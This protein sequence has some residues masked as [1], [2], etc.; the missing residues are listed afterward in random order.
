MCRAVLK[1]YRQIAWGAIFIW[2][3]IT[4]SGRATRLPVRVYSTADG[5]PSNQTNCV[6]RDSRGFLWF[7]TAEGLSRFDGYTFTN[8]GVD[9][10]LPD[11]AVTDFLETR[12]G[13]YWVATVR[14]L[15]RFDPK[16][17]PK[18][19]MFTVYRAEATAVAQEVNALLEDHQGA[20]WVG[21]NAGVFCLI[22]TG[23]QWVFRR[24][25]WGP[26]SHAPA[27]GF[28]EDR[29]G[30]LWTALYLGQ[31]A[32]LCRWSTAGKLDIFGNDFLRGNRILA[33][34]E[35]RQGRIWLG[36]YHGLALLADRPQADGP[37]I[38]H[39][40]AEQ[41]GLGNGT[42]STLYQ[43]SDGR[44][45]VTFRNGLFETETDAKGSQAHFTLYATKI[46]GVSAQDR[47][48]N[49]WAG[50]TR[51]ARNGFVSYGEADGLATEDV[52]AIFDGNDGALYVVTG[53]H[54]GFIHRFDGKR[55]AAVAPNVPG[56][57]LGW[58]WG[59]IHLQDHAGEWWV[60]TDHGLVRYPR[61]ARL[62]D[63]THTSPKAVYSKKDGLGGND[64]FRLFEDSRGDLWIGAWGGPGLARWERSSGRFH[65]FTAS[66]GWSGMPTAF[67]EDRAGDVWVGQWGGDLTRYRAGHF[68]RFGAADGFSEGSVFSIFSDHA[69]RLW[70]GTTRGGLVRIDDPS[71]ERPGFNVYSTKQGLSSNDVRAITE[72]HWGRIYFWTGRGVD[73]LKPETGAIRHYTEADGLV[74][75]GSDNNV[76]FCDHRGTLWFGLEGLS[77]LEPEPDRP[78]AA[79]PPIRI[80]KVRVRGTQYPTSELGETELSG[81]T[82]EPDQNELQ[83]EF[84]SLNFA[85]GD[86]IKYQYKL[87]G[88][89]TD[90]SAPTDLRVVNY[91]RLSPGNYRFLV[92]AINADGLVSAAPAAVSFRL[93]PPVW[94]RWWFLTLAALLAASLV[95][96]S[97]R[98]RLERLLQ[99]ERVRTRIATDLHD[100]IGSSL[101]QIAIMSE[102]AR[103][104]GTDERLAEPLARIAGLSRE[105]IDSMSDIVWA[106]NPKRDHLGDLAQRM[107]RFASDVLAAEGVETEFRIPIERADTSLH[108]DV[109][110]EA[111]LIF[112]ESINNIARHAQS[113]HVDVLLNLEGPQLVMIVRDNGRGFDLGEPN[114]QGH[115]LA[116]M[117][118]RARRLGGRLSVNSRPGGGT[119]VTLVVPLN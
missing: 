10:G 32:R 69:G 45:W 53:I 44:M 39:V 55:F 30:N 73:R 109:R 95:Y 16:P 27:E 87:E 56:H 74:P 96:W 66:E 35:D 18:A 40:Y 108:A 13:Q 83:V 86:V 118:E 24:P 4:V 59:Q 60:A 26:A 90:W 111:F 77:R 104:Q 78:E 23:G 88:A 52:R 29:D 63:L 101:T 37:L 110:R 82:F 7:C 19:P 6:K 94:S 115:G 58:G 57:N 51:I 15:A 47:D 46:E 93:L 1:P 116:S 33:M 12:T 34:L 106:I 89:E 80:T 31:A 41:N 22:R 43:S 70:A 91:P 102:V 114:G 113:K 20:I 14:G 99:L 117:S 61:V 84:A 21:T 105:L 100:D 8:Y 48:G 97:Y 42:V 72:D 81:L 119:S 79:P 9:Q 76:A 92:R 103:S 67:Q 64:I 62:E 68:R 17:G 28:L 71:A 50:T 49:L 2:M 112:K 107:R 3:V 38:E 5:L 98:F 25:A 85:V 54:G 11:Q 75:S 65:A 36:T